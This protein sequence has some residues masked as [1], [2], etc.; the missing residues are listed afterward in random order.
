MCLPNV[1]NVATK[2]VQ[3]SGGTVMHDK[4]VWAFEEL[5]DKQITCVAASR[6]GEYIVTGEC[7]IP[8]L[9]Q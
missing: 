7:T 4:D 3:C 1:C 6:D 9:H 2:C 5:H 8:T